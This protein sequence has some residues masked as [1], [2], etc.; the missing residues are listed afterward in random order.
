VSKLDILC[1]I[2]LLLSTRRSSDREDVAKRIARKVNFRLKREQSAELKTIGTMAVEEE[3]R[4]LA[5]G[6][7]SEGNSLFSKNA[8]ADA[9]EKYSEAIAHDP[10]NAVTTRHISHAYTLIS[11][12]SN[13]KRVSFS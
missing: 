4:V 8:F 6:C 2:I 12:K 13:L 3:V 5:E 1:D 11:L 9:I 7:K 10:E